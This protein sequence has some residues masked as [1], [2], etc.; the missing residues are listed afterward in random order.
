M[1]P[2]SVPNG[3]MI[4]TILAGLVVAGPAMAHV[5]LENQSAPVGAT[6]KAVLRVPHGCKGAATSTTTTWN[7]CSTVGKQT[8]CTPRSSTVEGKP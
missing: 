4:A 5:T 1:I 7:E 6:Y 2:A 3:F 8:Q